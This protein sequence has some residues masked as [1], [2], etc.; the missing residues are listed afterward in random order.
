MA[1]L[2]NVPILLMTLGDGRAVDRWGSSG[3]LIFEASVGI[4]AALLFGA[5]A[6]FTRGLT[7][8]AVFGRPT[9]R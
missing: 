6:Y 8:G 3:M 9:P 2:A 1:S 7:W 5:V 4:A